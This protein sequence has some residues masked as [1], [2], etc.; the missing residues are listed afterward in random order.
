MDRQIKHNL[1]GQPDYDWGM[2]DKPFLT[3]GDVAVR[4]AVQKDQ[5]EDERRYNEH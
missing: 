1:T 2:T 3:I 5:K 4:K